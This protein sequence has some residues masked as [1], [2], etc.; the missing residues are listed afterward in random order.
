M[1]NFN[2]LNENDKIV[3]TNKSHKNIIPIIKDIDKKIKLSYNSS[4]N[5]ITKPINEEK[6]KKVES[7]GQCKANTK[8]GTRCSRSAGTNGYCWQHGG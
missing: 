7:S 4:N 3:E 8:K 1:N 2:K 5:N 6:T